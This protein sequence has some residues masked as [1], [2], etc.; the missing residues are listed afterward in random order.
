MSVYCLIDSGKI[1]TM[2]VDFYEGTSSSP[3]TP[4]PASSSDSHLNA[5]QLSKAVQVAIPATSTGSASSSCEDVKFGRATKTSQVEV[6]IQPS[7]CEPETEKPHNPTNLEDAC[8]QNSYPNTFA[9]D[10][11]NL[12]HATNS[13]C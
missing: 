2:V 12:S 1:P 5:N 7:G 11:T 9:L 6:H 13:N 10:I 8:Q 4:T 3:C